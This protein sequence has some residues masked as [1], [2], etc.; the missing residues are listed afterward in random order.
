MAPK[1]EVYFPSLEKCLAGDSAIVSWSE[2]YARLCEIKPLERDEKVYKFLSSDET[3][4][5]LATS[6]EDTDKPTPQSKS[7]FETK[8]AAINITPASN[9]QYDIDQ[10]KSD[11]LWLS[12]EVNLDEVSAL[13]IV[14]LEWQ[15]RSKSKLRHGFTEAERA[16]LQAVLGTASFKGVDD[17]GREFTTINVKE[18]YDHSSGIFSSVEQRRLRMLDEYFGQCKFV[19][20]THERLLSIC[21]AQLNDQHDDFFGL[22]KEEPEQA[23]L[24]EILGRKVL[25]LQKKTELYNSGQ[26]LE[27]CTRKLESYVDQLA[28]GCGIFKAEGGR[29]DIDDAWTRINLQQMISTLNIMFLHIRSCKKVFT[30]SV[31]LQWLRFAAQ[32]DF[33]ERFKP[34]SDAQLALIPALRAVVVSVSLSILQLPIALTMLI[35]MSGKTRGELEPYQISAYFLDKSSV[36]EIHDILLTAAGGVLPVASP[37]VFAWG[38]LL[39]AVR[40]IGLVAKEAREEGHIQTSQEPHVHP[41]PNNLRRNSGSSIGSIQQSIYEDVLEAIRHLQQDDPIAFLITSAINRNNV[42]EIISTAAAMPG[43][44]ERSTA[45]QKRLCFIELISGSLGIVSYSQEVVSCLLELLNDPSQH[46]SPLQEATALAFIEDKVLMEGVFDEALSRFPYEPLPLLRLC[47]ALSSIVDDRSVPLVLSKIS[48]MDTFTQAASPGFH[49]FHTIREDEN[50]NLVSLDQ[51]LSMYEQPGVP[52]L[53]NSFAAKS[54]DTGAGV[55]LRPGTVGQVISD[56]RPPIIMWYHQY[57]GLAFLGKLLDIVK[58]G[59]DASFTYLNG[60]PSSIVASTIT[61]FARL[62]SSSL[63]PGTQKDSSATTETA[64][65]ILEDASDFLDRDLDIIS[66]VF[67][68]FERELHGLRYRSAGNRN[69]DVLVACVDFFHYT[70]AILPGRIW[71]LLAHSSLLDLEGTGGLLSSIV[72][73]VESSSGHYFFLQSCVHLFGSLIEEAMS[74]PAAVL[75]GPD[76]QSKS[77][78]KYNNISTAPLHVVSKVLLSATQTMAEVIEAS[79]E[80]RF[81]IPQQRSEI[82]TGI[83]SAFSEIIRYA[84]FIDDTPTL[85]KKLTSALSLSALFLLEGLTSLSTTSSLAS[86]LVRAMV[87]GLHLPDPSLDA[88]FF[89][90]RVAEVECCLK[91]SFDAIC[92]GR[93]IAK[94]VIGLETQLARSL[95][96]LIRLVAENERFVTQTLN[97]VDSLLT[98]D[99]SHASSSSS[100]LLAQLGPESSQNFLALLGRYETPADNFDAYCASWKLLSTLISSRQQWFAVF[101]LTGS[102]PQEAMKAC[103]ASS[104]YADSSISGGNSFLH[105]ALHILYRIEDLDSRAT[106]A[107]LNFVTLAQENWSWATSSI[108]NQSGF[109]ASLSNYV[110]K[111]DLKPNRPAELCYQIKIAAMIADILTVHFHH[112]R[113]IGESAFLK[114]AIPCLMWYCENAIAVSGYNGSLHSNLKKNLERKYPACQLLNFKKTAAATRQLGEDYFYDVAMAKKIL[115]HDPSWVGDK[116]RGFEHEID[117]ELQKPIASAANKCLRANTVSYPQEAIFDTVFQIRADLALALL[118][119]L[120]NARVGGA[121]VEALLSHAWESMRF[122]EAN[123]ENALANDDLGYWRTL[124]EVLFLALQFHTRSKT[125]DDTARPPS[126]KSDT[127]P[128]LLE[129]LT[130][131]VALGFRGM[132]GVLHDEQIPAETV[133]PKD[134]G[135]LLGILQTSLRIPSLPR[136]TSDISEHLISTDVAKSAVLLFSWAHTLVLPS[137]TTNDLDP[138]FGEISLSFLVSLSTLPLLAECLATSAILSQLSSTHLTQIITDGRHPVSP[139][140]TKSSLSRRLY[141]IWSTGILPLSLNLLSHVGRNFASEIAAFLNQFPAQLTQAASLL[142]P[143]DT[144]ALSKTN[145]IF[146]LT[147]VSYV[148][149]AYRTAGPSAGVDA[150]EIPKLVGWDEKGRKELREDIEDLLE[151]RMRLRKCILATNAK[152]GEMLK[153]KPTQQGQGHES[154]LEEKIVE[155]MKGVLIILRGADET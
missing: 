9:G 10:I 38:T 19:M 29:D 11:A 90:A 78:V 136:L 48:T 138:I 105:S 111:I 124:A 95:P 69:L 68:I 85:S 112:M 117:P 82:T 43:S 113:S 14:V 128:I 4:N 104:S 50:A 28:S 130:V 63:G 17:A 76:T 98:L 121:E 86:P 30:A 33:L 148:L 83:Y 151:S 155:E 74:L 80:W 118:Q 7:D 77:T 96:F 97:V 65:S 123:F 100:S 58:H 84:L 8:T 129:I 101:I 45:I 72:T 54:V 99:E 37:A 137:S 55:V 46:S 3:L 22:A 134:F 60:S 25:K 57:S 102:S 6:L 139:F 49:Q 71:P 106:M 35:D 131:V 26:H 93:S 51:M 21:F 132:A 133:T 108:R 73:S 141:S 142:S 154:L 140:D 125:V 59:E 41:G 75:M 119:R 42:F 40:D 114:K 143:S 5:H 31:V 12:K 127:L 103:P 62:L 32:Y 56:S 153:A 107:V 27:R 24:T 53:E 79:V 149:D 70:I 36:S 34:S 2:A 110:A 109:L 122:R 61:L 120:N 67:E 150:L 81:M 115:S 18:P 16:T 145:E 52:H 66:L 144:I 23:P 116:T 152:E 64:Q 91:F 13:R 147:L 94:P 15:N 39:V 135:L 1:S 47:T 44:N 20:A 92:S 146:T 87:G 88:P 89:E 126:L